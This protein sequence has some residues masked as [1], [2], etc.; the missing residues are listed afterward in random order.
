[1]S[2]STLTAGQDR[3]RSAIDDKYKWN[4][5]DVYPD[6][7]AWRTAKEACAR[8]LPRLRSHQGKLESSAQLLADAGVSLPTEAVVL[9]FVATI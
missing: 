6:L 5:T 9:S 7:R 8:E 3:E 2:A 4:L 1:L